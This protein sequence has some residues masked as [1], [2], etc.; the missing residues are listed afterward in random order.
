MRH[1]LWLATLLLGGCA[2]QMIEG[3]QIRDTA[4]N[5]EILDV[6]TKLQEAMRAR[7]ADAI[8]SMV[9]RSYFEDNGTPDQKDDYGYEELSTQILPQSLEV[10]TE[11]FVTFEVYEIVVDD[12]HA[13][14]DIRYASR[15]KV[16]LPSGTLWDSHREFNRVELARGDDGAWMITSGL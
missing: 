3:T 16:E 15:T 1:S 9:S 11:L 2:H 13:H 12:A 6:L 4:E 7:D 5:R 14:A 10:A 8:L